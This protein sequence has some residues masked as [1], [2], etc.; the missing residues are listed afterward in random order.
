MKKYNNFEL[1]W[2]INN[3]SDFNEALE[4]F[5]EWAATGAITGK[6]VKVKDVI[7]DTDPA[8]Y[9]G[10]SRGDKCKVGR[11]VSN[12]YANNKYNGICSGNKKGSTKT[13]YKK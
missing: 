2:N 11:A 8:L 9:D 10:L 3:Y 13:Y 4:I 5:N 1:D 12:R 7:K 6:H